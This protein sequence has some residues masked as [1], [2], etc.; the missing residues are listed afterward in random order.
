[1]KK[2]CK[3]FVSGFAVFFAALFLMG[4]TML[5]SRLSPA[6]VK[7]SAAEQIVISPDEASAAPD[8]DVAQPNALGEW[9]FC[10]ESRRFSGNGLLILDTGYASNPS[11]A[12]TLP[13]YYKS[14]A[15]MKG[16]NY[17]RLSV[18]FNFEFQEAGYD[19]DQYVRIVDSSGKVL[20][21]EK[22]LLDP[23]LHKKSI[24]FDLSLEDILYRGG[25]VVQFNADGY[26]KDDWNVKYFE[27]EM[28]YYKG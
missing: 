7:T 23:S 5:F 26:G 17:T 1:M 12:F 18:N 21:Q 22:Y 16:L 4:A 11:L 24:T 25:I 3:W 27:M 6:F 13:Y 14:F 19:G 28:A 8:A 20:A 2:S 15:E 9:V 10:N